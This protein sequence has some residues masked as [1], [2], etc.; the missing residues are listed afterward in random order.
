M[1]EFKK[2]IILDDLDFK[3]NRI[4]E[5]LNHIYND[6]PIKELE[7]SR[8]MMVEIRSNRDDISVFEDTILFLDWNFPFYKGEMVN[9]N[10]GNHILF[11][12]SRYKLPLK[13]II[14]SSDEVIYDKEEYPFVLGT[15]KDESC[16]WQLDEYEKLLKGN[17]NE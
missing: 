15:I 14:V 6:I 5:Y 16:V 10:E 3:R 1:M 8:D 12:I 7:C 2:A 4:K 13:V 9:P 11:Y 17:S